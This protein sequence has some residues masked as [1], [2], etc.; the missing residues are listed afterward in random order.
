MRTTG[1]AFSPGSSPGHQTGR[2][3]GRA[4]GENRAGPQP[5]DREGPGPRSTPDAA[6]PR[7]RG[8]RMMRRRDFITLIGAT[9]GLPLAARAQ[10]GERVRRVGLLMSTAED[11]VESRERIDAFLR[12]LARF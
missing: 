5:K 12:E 6:R 7:R 3:P 4:S 1:S 9:V 8:D 10:Q 2:P 11:D